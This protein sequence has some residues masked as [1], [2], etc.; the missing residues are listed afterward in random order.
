[1]AVFPATLRAKLETLR[2]ADSYEVRCGETSAVVVLDES[3]RILAARLPNVL[4]AGRN[5]HL[6]DLFGHAA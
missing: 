5:D 1:M 3:G 2:A 6:S 4:T